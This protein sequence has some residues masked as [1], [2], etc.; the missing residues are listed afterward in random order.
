MTPR[1]Y[2]MSH[3][4]AS[5]AARREQVI[6]TAIGLF[7]E[8]TA[9][10][11]TMDDV[12]RAAGVAPAT[13]YR[14]FKDFDGLALACAEKA[15]HITEIPTPEVAVEQFA[16]LDSLGEKLYRFIEIS[17]ECYER[18]QLWLAAERRERHLPAFAR[19]VSREEAAL[20]AIVSGLLDPVGADQEHRA[21]IRTLTDFPFWQS[22]AS[23]G[24]AG[25]RIPLVV[26]DLCADE[27]RRAGIK[28]SRPREM[29]G[30]P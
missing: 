3:R 2:R 25:R 27:L 9:A 26:F 8:N 20:E 21:V 1:R 11:T 18:A 23:S 28:I 10:A 14:Q 6:E 24:V 16:A 17:C 13:V 22:L 19:T 7:A 5:V 4:A 12:A 15:F 29:E 30:R